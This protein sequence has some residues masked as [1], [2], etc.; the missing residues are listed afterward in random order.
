MKK[1]PNQHFPTPTAKEAMMKCGK[2][3]LDFA[4]YILHENIEPA[5]R[6]RLDNL[7][8]AVMKS[9]DPADSMYLFFQDEGYDVSSEECIKIVQTWQR[10]FIVNP[11]CD[12]DGG[13][14]S[15]Y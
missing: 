1:D 7:W 6:D 13:A 4:R 11:D 3:F 8:K 10:F 9:P 15:A 5:E 12:D 2:T 14:P